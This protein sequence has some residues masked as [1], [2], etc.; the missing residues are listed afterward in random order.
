MIKGRNTTTFRIDRRKRMEVISQCSHPAVLTEIF[1]RADALVFVPKADRAL[2][3]E[4]FRSFC[5]E[6]PCIV[7]QPEDQTQRHIT[8]VVTR[9]A[10]EKITTVPRLVYTITHVVP[11]QGGPLMGD[12]EVLHTCGRNGNN[13]TGYGT[14]L[15]PDHLMRSDE[16]GR[17]QLA[18]IRRGARKLGLT[19]VRA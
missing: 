15:N 14:C 2:A 19:E 13:S 12:E 1:R 16:E 3:V 9:E 4:D 10:E 11:E 6:Q 17:M 7:W 8:V 5:H 18:E